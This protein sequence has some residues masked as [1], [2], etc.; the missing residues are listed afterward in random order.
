LQLVDSRHGP[1][2]LDP[3]AAEGVVERVLARRGEDHGSAALA[4]VAH[5]RV[6]VLLE[7]ERAPAPAAVVPGSRAVD[8]RVGDGVLARALQRADLGVDLEGAEAELVKRPLPVADDG[9]VRRPR[10]GARLLA[11]APAAGEGEEQDDHRQLV[12]NETLGTHV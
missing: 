6:D 8:Q 3:Y 10:A 11:S 2:A 4:A 9:E 7:L 1:A 5:S 12:R